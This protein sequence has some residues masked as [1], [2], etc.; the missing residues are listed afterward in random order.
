MK[1]QLMQMKIKIMIL[2]LMK[3][4][5]LIKKDILILINFGKINKFFYLKLIII[6]DERI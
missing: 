1:I 3:I 5:I 6:N 2:I 4:L